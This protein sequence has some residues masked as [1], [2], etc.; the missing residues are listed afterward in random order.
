[1][2]FVNLR[3][4]STFAFCHVSAF[5]CILLLSAFFGCRNPA[6]D[7]WTEEG[8][9]QY[10]T[11]REYGGNPDQ[12]KFV[13]LNDITKSNVNNLKE[14]WF[15][16]TGDENTYQFNPIVVDT[17]MYV[18][19]RNNSLV[20]LDARTGKEIWIHAHLQGIASRGINYWESKDRKD[21]RLIFQMNN[22]LQAIDARTGKSVLTFGNNGLV[23]LKEGLGRDPKTL[24][25]V[26]SGTPGK[27]FE[28]LIILGSSPG[29]NY[30]SGPGHLR[31][32]DVVT[33]KLAWTFHTIPHPGEFGYDTWPKE[34]YKY[35]GGV[36]TWGEISLDVKRGIAYF[37]LGSPTYDYYGGDR[38]GSNLFGN[39]ILALDARTGKRIWHYQ[40]VHHDLW[41]YDATA[42]PQLITVLPCG[43]SRRARY[44]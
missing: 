39:S 8:Y 1:M 9:E 18:L 37:P 23:D 41:D 2:Q 32:F 31:A 29:E 38:H 7:E 16:P 36:N 43:P 40:M 21:R 17:M 25:R 24:A 27:V 35:I 4:S 3:L 33:G 5:W 22:Y 6:Q 13:V 15:Y 19:A 44:R 11:W 12:S 14:A 26:Q 28:N 20:A 34:A 42:A 30:L 10:K